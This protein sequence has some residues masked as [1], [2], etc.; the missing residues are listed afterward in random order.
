MRGGWWVGWLGGL[1]LRTAIPKG[2]LVAEK[3]NEVPDA[4]LVRRCRQHWGAEKPLRCDEEAARTG[5]LK[6]VLKQIC[7]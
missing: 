1:N 5:L 3:K 2:A 4:W 7:T 6:K